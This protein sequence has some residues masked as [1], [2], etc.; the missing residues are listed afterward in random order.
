MEMKIE[1]KDGKQIIT[2]PSGVISEYTKEQ[3]EAQR[4]E[5]EKQKV[6]VEEEIEKISEDISKL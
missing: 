5:L 4:K 1:F 2:H 6:R 3:M